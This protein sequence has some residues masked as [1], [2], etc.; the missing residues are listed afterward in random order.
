MDI[1]RL[2][3]R[4]GLSIRQATHVGQVLPNNAIES[5]YRF[6]HLIIKERRE[7]NINDGEDFG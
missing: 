3:Q 1:I 4:K 7:L 2:L 6:F 5:F